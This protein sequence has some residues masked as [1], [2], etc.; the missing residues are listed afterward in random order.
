MQNII[1]QSKKKVNLTTRLTNITRKWFKVGAFSRLEPDLTEN[2]ELLQC[3]VVAWNF[4]CPAFEWH[5]VASLDFDRCVKKA[6]ERR[7]NSLNG[8]RTP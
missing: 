3:L 5:C 6:T 8:E 1:K 4:I 2:I 7:T